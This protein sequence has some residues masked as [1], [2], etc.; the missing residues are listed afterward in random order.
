MAKPLAWLTAAAVATTGVGVAVA[1]APR[2]DPEPPPPK[3]FAFVSR[4]G[5][6]ELERLSRVG[7]RI[8]VVAPNWYDLVPDSGMLRAPT[9]SD[10]ERL[11]DIAQARRV[12]VWPTV[13]ARTRGSQEWETPV[14][15]ARI[16]A[17]LR[18]AALAPGASGVTLDM[19]ELSYDQ[20][21]AFTTL[22]REAASALHAAD[23]RLAVY[24]SRT[25]A[26][27]DWKALA[28]HADLLLAAGYNESWAGSRPGPVTTPK[29]F[30]EVVDRSLKAAG[31]R[32]AVP[33]LGAFGYRWPRTGRGEL[34]ASDDALRLRRRLRVHGQRSNGNER[35]TSG[36]D[37]IVY[38]TAAGLRARWSEAASAGVRWIGLFSLGREP[39]HFWDDLETAR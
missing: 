39:E 21:D 16:V 13:N 8:D 34:I 14:A 9:G 20:R 5:G 1:F 7:A 19:E 36:G 3:V 25:G 37:T 15:R 2:R 24:V 6:A 4:H 30:E 28:R 23:R 17:S 12:R 27:Y 26:E 31:R 18:A 33:L 29:G 10:R 38:A 32:K 22:V 11:L 35:F